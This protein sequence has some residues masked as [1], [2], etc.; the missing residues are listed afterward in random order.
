MDRQNTIR[1]LDDTF[2]ND[3]D[4]GLFL[5]FVK[6]LFKKFNINQKT[7]T[8]WE[9]YEEFIDSFQA[10]GTYTDASRHT[11]D[12]LVVKLKKTSSRDRARTMQRNFIA[13]YLRYLQKDSAL[14]VFY[15]DDPQDWRFSFVKLEYQIQRIGS[16]K[17]KVIEIP[18]PV[19]RSSFLVG[20]NEPNHTCKSQF[21]NILMQDDTNPTLEDIE[22]AFSID[23][24]TKEFFIEYKELYSELK[25]VLDDLIKKNIDIRREFDDKAISTIDF[26]KK[27]LGQIVFIYFLQKKGWLGVEKDTKS[28]KFRD[29]GSGPKNFLRRLFERKNY[30]NFFN[31]VLEPL[32][33]EAL[34][35]ERDDDYYSRFECK[36]PFLNGGLFEP[37]NDYNWREIDLLL[38]NKIFEKIL[39]T[40]DRF[41]F[42]VKE[43]EPLEKE[44]AIDPEMLGKVFENLIE[45]NIRKG[46]GAYYTPREIVHYMCQQSLI[47]YIETNTGI[48]REDIEKFIQ[49]AD[50]ALDI[51]INVSDEEHK[52][53]KS[54]QENYCKIDDLLKNI[55]IV[56]PA[57]GSG[58]FPVG[59]MNEIVKARSI[60]SMFFSDDKQEER[61]NYNLKR[62]AIENCLY[63]VDIDSSAVDIA[64]LR[65]WLSLI[66]DET[67]MK[68]IKPL[69]NL[70]HKIM[71]GN[72]LLEE[73]EGIKLFDE[74]L[75]GEIKN[76]FSFEIKQIDNK[77]SQLYKEKGEI[78]R[79]KKKG[80]IKDI[81]REIKKLEKSK[82]DIKNKPKE[83]ERNLTLREVSERKIKESQKKLRELRELQKKF[84]NEQN[85]KLKKQFRDDIERIEWELITE[86]LKEQGNEEAMKKLQ[87]Y[88]KNKSKPFFLWKLYFAEVFQRENPG[89]D[90]VIAN[91]PYIKEYVNR[92]VFDG[93]HD[94]PYYQG[95]MDIWYFFACKSIDLMRDN[96]VLTF[97]AQNNWVTSYGA[98]I[99]R[100]KVIKETKII[101]LINFGDYKIFETGIQTMIM[102]FQHD[103]TSNNYTFDMRRIIGKETT[104]Q[105]VL[106]LLNY[107]KNVKN[108]YLSP[109]VNRELLTDK[110]L[111]FSN[112]LVEP[113]IQK[114]IKLSNFKLTEKEVANGIHHHHDLLNKERQK[115]LGGNFKIGDGIFVLSDEEKKKLN[116]SR[117][118]LE[119]IKP[120]YTTGELFRYYANPKNKEWVIYTDSKF[121]NP[122]Q[123]VSYPNIKKHLDKFKE[124]ITSDNKPYGLHRSRE[125]YFFKGE[126]IIAV[127]KCIV[128]S[129]TYTNFDSYVS[130][131]F[132]IIKSSR[133]N[134]KYLTGLL[135]S[136]LI[137]FWLRNKGKMQGN[138]YQIDKEPLLD[139][140]IINP[141][142]NQQKPFIQL[143][144]QIL[145]ITKDDDYLD[146]PEKQA[147]VKKL[148]KEIDQ[149]VYK[150]YELTLEEI[151]IVENFMKEND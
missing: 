62:E 6:E 52:L 16:E 13:K 40:F 119:L 142:Q 129:F 81:E 109:S 34:A 134:L 105:D 94:S 132:Y 80:S 77:I 61:T 116:L 18:T 84:F 97:I 66:V 86:T 122:R 141:L 2:G 49:L 87:Q 53:P 4:M 117:K 108:E 135:N 83:N 35:T 67:D 32:F 125:E 25:K 22:S 151:E 96:G 1:L 143:I 136:K 11:I 38:G 75:L 54:I 15:G 28:G 10:V 64:K 145:A 95:K 42:T 115:I 58:A 12:V 50:F 139:I 104:F 57:V 21:V 55:K 36:I 19:K 17:G 73:F 30:G 69:P 7:L 29:W 147:K 112:T 31:D 149:L 44:V 150:L 85:R 98:S 14:V 126:K 102:I 59:M 140:P 128:P 82:K 92:E 9:E 113:L 123:I 110:T 90:V 39:D 124:V 45:Y 43:D 23:K 93:L 118:E 120:S 103:D 127:R 130:A 76:D 47:N 131:T 41:N 51:L 72:S 146:N 78:S 107:K 33:Y 121:K 8:V 101:N 27:L 48:A 137:E 65:F 99:L 89:F 79:G 111:T 63:G 148:E 68:N 100:N 133:I 56:D 114:M 88:K 91:P 70:D 24:I 60:L 74:R 26:T 71:C 37:I 5:K 138:N 20:K 106:D 46:Q 144:D 3:F